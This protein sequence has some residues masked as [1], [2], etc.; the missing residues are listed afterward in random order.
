M[1]KYNRLV[2]E[3]TT[4]QGKRKL[5]KCGAVGGAYA[6]DENNVK[7]KL[8]EI[9]FERVDFVGGLWRVQRDFD[10]KIQMVRGKE[11]VLLSKIDKQEKNLFEYYR[12]ATVANNCYGLYSN[13]VPDY[14]VAKYDTDNGTLWAYGPTLE[15]ARAFLGIALFDKHIDLIHAA[16]RKNIQKQK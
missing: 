4:E 13:M 3:Y 8:I 16:E 9:P 10:K 15:Q 14:V 5:W 6:I 1:F 12:A 7:Y 2:T 11:F